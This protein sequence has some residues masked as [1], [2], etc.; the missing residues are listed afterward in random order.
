LD[1]M[2]DKLDKSVSRGK[3]SDVEVSKRKLEDF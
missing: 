1:K 3:L 2:K